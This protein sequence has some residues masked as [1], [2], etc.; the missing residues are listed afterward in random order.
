MQKKNNGRFPRTSKPT[1]ALSGSLSTELKAVDTFSNLATDTTGA[2]LLVNGLVPGVGFSQRVGREVHVRHLHAEVTSLVTA[3]TGADQYHRVLLV[4]DRQPNGAA[5]A[6]TD[7]LTAVSPNALPNL[8]NQARFHIWEDRRVYLNA[9]AEPS[10]G[11]VWSFDFPLSIRT[12]YNDGVAGTVADIVTNSL[13]VM[14]MGNL[15]A[16]VTAGVT[17]INVRVRYSDA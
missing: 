1:R 15:V 4:Q 2:I 3:G 5:P 11:K 8:I 9:S 12:H 16:G 6:I 13:Y 10:S 17:T 14:V 7:V